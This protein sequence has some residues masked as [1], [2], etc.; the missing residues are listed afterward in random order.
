MEKTKFQILLVDDDKDVLKVFRLMLEHLGHQVT[1]ANSGL[2]AITLFHLQPSFFDLVISD[3]NMPTM[4]GIAMI[5][6]I[7]SIRSDIPIILCT[8]NTN[9]PNEQL[10][11]AQSLSK[12]IL[13]PLTLNKMK[14]AIKEVLNISG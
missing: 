13:K 2:E 11:T 9:L 5:K 4:D 3:I 12:I 8:G 6:E 10:K 14:T 7:I 1:T